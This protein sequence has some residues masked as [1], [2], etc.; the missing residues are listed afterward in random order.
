MFLLFL[1][2]GLW[3]V[4]AV[5]D[6]VEEAVDVLYGTQLLTVRTPAFFVVV[7][8][9]LMLVSGVGSKAVVHILCCCVLSVHNNQT[10]TQFLGANFKLKNHCIFILH[11]PCCKNPY[12]TNYARSNSP[13]DCITPL[14]TYYRFVFFEICEKRKF[15]AFRPV[16]RYSTC[17]RFLRKHANLHVIHWISVIFVSYVCGGCN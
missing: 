11:L 7:I 6:V 16:A 2:D 3:P 1:L 5:V 4:G 10:Q 12:P 15:T 17:T 14:P 8:H 13:L 9:P